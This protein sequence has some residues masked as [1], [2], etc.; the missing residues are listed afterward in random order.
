VK[1]KFDDGAQMGK[2]D[3][4]YKYNPRTL[5]LALAKIVGVWY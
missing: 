5:V 4:R 1:K 2:I 3:L